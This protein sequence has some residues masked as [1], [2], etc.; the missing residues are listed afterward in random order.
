MKLFPDSNSTRTGR[1]GAALLGGI[2]IG[3]ALMYLLDPDRG[4][5]RRALIRDKA[6]H[7]VHI[8]S[9]RLGARSRDLRNRAQGL[10]AQVLTGEPSSSADDVLEARIRSEIGHVTRNPGA[11]QVFARRGCVTLAGPVLSSEKAGLIARVQG[12]PGIEAVED[13]LEPHDSP[14]DIPALQGAKGPRSKAERGA[15]RFE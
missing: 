3:A 11:I 1:P 12:I 5:R 15:G 6:A 10:A 7:L 13:R 2:G 8:A 14:G 4:R 9:N